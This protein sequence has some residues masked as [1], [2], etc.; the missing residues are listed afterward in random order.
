[1]KD[2]REITPEL[3]NAGYPL[4]GVATAGQPDQDHLERLAE[5]G[6]RTVLD[7]RTLEE[8]PGFDESETVRNAGMKY[9]NMPLEVKPEAFTDEAF[10]RARELLADPDHR[11][12]LVHCASAVRVAPL[13]IPYLIL[14]E[15]RSCDEA[16]EIA[17]W[18]GPQ[19]EEL[20]DVAL[21]YVNEKQDD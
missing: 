4:E 20:T 5:A 7:V 10:D 17:S 11:P 9:V 16:V 3:E 19:Q 1:M 2:V 21:R 14:E 12:I 13:L 8:D 6:Y 18:V 15:G